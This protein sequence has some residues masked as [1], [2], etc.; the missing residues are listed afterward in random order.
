MTLE[1]LRD[2]AIIILT[3][4]VLVE[5]ILVIVLVAV[6]IWVTVVL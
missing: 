2:W 6:L 5:T 4:F 3:I 1:N